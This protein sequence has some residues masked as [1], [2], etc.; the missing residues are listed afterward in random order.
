MSGGAVWNRGG[1]S[2]S[3]TKRFVDVLARPAARE[4]RPE[5]KRK[6]GKNLFPSVAV[7][8]KAWIRCPVRTRAR[9]AGFLLPKSNLASTS[10]ILLSLGGC[11][12]VRDID[13]A[14]GCPWAV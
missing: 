5:P 1:V 6:A 2:A 13:G 11:R 4:P 9:L 14:L 8:S 12:V 7:P 10:E 3:M